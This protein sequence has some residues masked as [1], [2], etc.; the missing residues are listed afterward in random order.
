MSSICLLPL[1]PQPIMSVSTANARTTAPPSTP[2]VVSRTRSR[3]PW[4]PSCRTWTWPSVRPGETPGDA[5]T[6]NAR[7]PSKRATAKCGNKH[8]TEAFIYVC[9]CACVFVFRWEVDPDYC[10][11]VKQTPPYDKG[12][13][14][15]DVMDMTVFDFL[16]GTSST[17]WNQTNNRELAKV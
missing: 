3:A 1:S 8:L 13:R 2:C 17:S 16:M 14:L 11:E 7:K 9:V 12:T 10:D 15:L 4:Q 6:T 5:H